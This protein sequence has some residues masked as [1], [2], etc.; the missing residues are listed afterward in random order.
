[1]K[2]KIEKLQL[3]PTDIVVVRL[4]RPKPGGEL[5]ALMEERGVQMIRPD[6]AAVT[7]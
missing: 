5:L 4:K 1:M 7:I 3:Q 2:T 6:P